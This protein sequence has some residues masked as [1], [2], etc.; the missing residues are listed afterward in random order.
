MPRRRP[1]PALTK[2]NPQTPAHS[3]HGLELYRP[4]CESNDKGRAAVNGV[5]SQTRRIPKVPESQLNH[6][7]EERWFADN[8]LPTFIARDKDTA[9]QHA[10]TLAIQ[11]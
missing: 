6:T 11:T 4:H 2:P 1:I 9:A 8:S 7:H 3:L 5:T 10:R